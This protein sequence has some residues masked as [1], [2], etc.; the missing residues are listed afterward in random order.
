M[1]VNKSQGPEKKC[2]KSNNYLPQI[3]VDPEHSPAK[4]NT[5]LQAAAE[6]F[7][8]DQTIAGNKR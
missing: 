8:E 5:G 4:A 7:Y 2:G 1:D 6:I 3:Q